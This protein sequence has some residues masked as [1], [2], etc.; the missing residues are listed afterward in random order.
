MSHAVVQQKSSSAQTVV[1]QSLHV[2]SS[3]SP[4]SQVSCAHALSLQPQL[5]IAAAAATQGLLD[6]AFFARLPR[7]VSRPAS[8]G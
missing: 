5:S 2:A 1:A 4:V 8:G 7:G 6:A 3:A